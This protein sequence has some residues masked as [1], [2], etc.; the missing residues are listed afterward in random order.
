MKKEF[1]HE[2]WENDQIGFHQEE[3]NP[4]LRTYWQS[5]TLAPNS[6]VFVPMCGKSLDMVWLRTQ[7][8]DVLGVELSPK[9]V[10]DF[11]GQ[12]EHDP[13]K[14][15]S[16]KFKGCK[17][18]G[19]SIL[20]GDF[21]DLD[22]SKTGDVAA[23]YDRA[24]LVALPPDMRKRYVDHLVQIL[25]PEVLILLITM[26]YPKA[27]MQGPPFSV[28]TREIKA[29]YSPH[30]EVEALGQFDV[31]SANPRFQERGLSALK[32]NIYLI[33]LHK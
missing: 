17:Y 32:E 6:L 10:S 28:T 19:I 16:G 3:I 18:D 13:E 15:S 21:F 7:G 26:E 12:F 1:W 5:L 29:L 11:F 2:R 8:H 23:V 30:G 4:Y 27:E 14:F 24:S 33:R 31:L 9:A 25:P 20:C 22:F